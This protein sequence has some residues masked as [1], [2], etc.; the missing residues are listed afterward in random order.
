M[1]IH[2]QRKQYQRQQLQTDKEQDTIK[3]YTVM[4]ILTDTLASHIPVHIQ[5]PIHT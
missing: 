1:H 3:Q 5:T 4:L 2:T